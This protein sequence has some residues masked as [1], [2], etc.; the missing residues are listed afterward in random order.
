[1]L[2]RH[3]VVANAVLH[4]QWVG[5]HLDECGAGVRQ[6]GGKSR[7]QIGGVVS[8]KAASATEFG[9]A[10]EIRVMQLGLPHVPECGS[11]LL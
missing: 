7:V 9:E 1:M 2:R 11:L 5:D 10:R 3:R 4:Q 6:R 8:A